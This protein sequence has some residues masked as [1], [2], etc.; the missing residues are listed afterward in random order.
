MADPRFGFI[1]FTAV[2]MSA[3]LKSARIFWSA[4]SSDPTVSDRMEKALPESEVKSII[5]A[6]IKAS[7]VM[8]RGIAAELDLRYI[9]KLIFEYDRSLATGAAMESLLARIS[10]DGR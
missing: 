10:S 4:I 3:D 6:L 9:P 7:G 8:K 2:R 5:D 1:T